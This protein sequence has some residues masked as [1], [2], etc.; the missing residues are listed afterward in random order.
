MLE[1]VSSVLPALMARWPRKGHRIPKQ[2]CLCSKGS[3]K[4]LAY[5]S[6]TAQL[7]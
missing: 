4:R 7:R 1:N 2:L 5:R 6:D 3:S